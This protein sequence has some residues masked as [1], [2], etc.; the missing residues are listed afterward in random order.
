MRTQTTLSLFLSTLL[1][2]HAVHA[3]PVHLWSHN[4]GDFNDQFV[5]AC[6]ADPSGNVILCG[7]FYG[8]MNIA[9]PYTSLGARDAIIAKWDTNGFPM[10]SKRVGFKSVDTGWSG[11]SDVAGN[12]IMVG[13]SGPHPNERDAFIAKYT[14]DGTQS[15]IK[16]FIATP[17]S[18]AYVEVVATDLTKHIHVAGQFNGS[19]NLGGSTL[20]AQGEND[21][22][23]AEFDAAGNHIWS[24]AFHAQEGI[25]ANGIAVDPS[26]QPVLFGSFSGSVNFGGG[27]LNSVSPSDLYLVKFDTDGNHMWSRRFGATG[28][29][30]GGAMAMDPSGRV[31]IT[32]QMGGDV[33]FGGGVMTP[34]S[35]TDVYLAM[36]NAA[37]THQWSKHFGGGLWQGGT[38]LAFAS[39][40]DVL[41]TAWAQGPGSIDFGGGALTV[42]GSYTDVTFVARFFSSTGA[43]RWSKQFSSNSSFDAFA[44]E[45]NGQLILGGSFY[46]TANLGGNDLISG[47][48]GD[49]FVGRFTDQLT[50]AGPTLAHASLLQNTP[51]PFNPTTQ[52][53]YTLAAPARAVI[54]I[55]DVSGKMVTR[56]D[57]G[58]QPAGAH[59]TL[60][61]GRDERG[62]PAASGVYFY[63]LSGM[64]EAGARKMVLLK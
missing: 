11:T 50:A 31:V 16:Y 58:V 18:I 54:E 35:T 38:G 17:D 61:N 4:Y 12:L 41:L 37:G 44:D 10:W 26:G 20:V 56:I 2:A 59:N 40:N 13:S 47:G 33:N 53:A 21:I 32:G 55:V 46:G 3:T 51:N 6:F 57:E 1:L 29:F 62:A 48:E 23:W 24:K 28:G 25:V 5:G 42:A 43:H 8:S 34:V 27:A 19:M 9:Q 52:I 49:F 64:P 22:F 63:W 14:P 39:N 36:F 60:W 15:W 30:G 7:S 45:Y